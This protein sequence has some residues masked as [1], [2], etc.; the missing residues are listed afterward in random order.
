MF[1]SL[2]SSEND[3][4]SDSYS[5][6]DDS[7]D[8]DG[9]DEDVPPRFDPNHIGPF[10]IHESIMYSFWEFRR[11]YHKLPIAQDIPAIHTSCQPLF[12]SLLPQATVF[13]HG[14]FARALQT[15]KSDINLFIPSLSREE[16]ETIWSNSPLRKPTY[17]D[18]SVDESINEHLRDLLGREVSICCSDD[19]WLWA[20][21]ERKYQIYPILE[22]GYLPRT[23]STPDRRS[24]AINLLRRSR[25]YIQALETGN[26]VDRRHPDQPVKYVQDGIMGSSDPRAC[27][28]H[29][30]PY[31]NSR[32]YR[33]ALILNQLQHILSGITDK[34][35]KKLL[36]SIRSLPRLILRLKG[37]WHVVEFNRDV[38][39]EDNWLWDFVVEDYRV[40]VKELLALS[41]VALSCST[42]I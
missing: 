26:G 32:I 14:S 10:P 6:S 15:D 5:S 9:S 34:E 25:Y 23:S 37:L 3:S 28:S 40:L 8:S 31:W 36:P 39:D 24:Y 33:L 2:T 27:A 29:R 41:D 11:A 19:P 4:D 38:R 17:D 7:D 21:Y 42:D 16:L 20:A 22:T 12:E 18:P 1:P 35:W 13:I 30:L